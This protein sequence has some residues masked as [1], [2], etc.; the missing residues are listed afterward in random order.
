MLLLYLLA[1]S[2]EEMSETKRVQAA[3][4][5]SLSD[6]FSEHCPSPVPAAA[7]SPE[8]HEPSPC[9]LLAPYWL[10]PH[11]TAG[12]R[13]EQG[14]APKPCSHPDLNPNPVAQP[15]RKIPVVS[16]WHGTEKSPC[17]M[18]AWLVHNKLFQT[19][20]KRRRG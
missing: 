9:S 5:T 13:W 17:C 15:S 8:P 4:R 3:A 11:P 12:S 20:C 14:S 1:N 19:T 7:L 18:S 2:E 16:C 10:Q 6:T